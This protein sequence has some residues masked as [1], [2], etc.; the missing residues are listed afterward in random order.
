VAKQL[1]YDQVAERKRKAEEFLRDVKED[2]ERADEVADEPVEDYAA[3]R[4]F[5]IIGNSPKGRNQ[6]MAEPSRQDLQDQISDL[7]AEND[8]LQ[9]QLDAISD[10]LDQDGDDDDYDNGD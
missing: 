4:Q 3:R 10:I 6:N 1:T 2:D 9:S 5:S 8:S 7:E